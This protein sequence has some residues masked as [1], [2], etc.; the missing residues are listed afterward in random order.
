MKATV[1]DKGGFGTVG[2]GGVEIYQT[3]MLR[4]LGIICIHVYKIE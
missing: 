1:D 4:S 3:M 2:W